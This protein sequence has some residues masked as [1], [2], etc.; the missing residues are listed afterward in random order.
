MIYLDNAATTYPKP[1]NVINSLKRSSLKY[2]ANIGRGGYKMSMDTA[3]MVFKVRKSIADFYDCDPDN[4]VFTLNCTT[5]VN[6]V[7]KGILKSGDHL[8]ISSLE[9]NAV[10]R[11]AQA[12]LKNGVEVSVAEVDL[13]SDERT[14]LNFE[15]LIKPNTKLIFVT[16][17][18]NVFGMRLPINELGE[19]ARNYGIMFGVDGA[20]ESGSGFLSFRNDNMNFLCIAPHKGLYAPL[21]T[22]I[23]ITDKIFDTIIEGGTGTNSLELVQPPFLPERLESGTQ[24]TI[25]ILAIGEGIKFINRTGRDKIYDHEFRLLKR[26]YK[27]LG[28]NP[29]VILYTGEP[30]YNKTAP[31]ISFNVRGFSSEETAAYLSRNNIAVRGGLHCA[32]L[33]HRF[34]KTID[35]GT[36][37]AAFSAFNRDIDCDT[38]TEK[39][40]HMTTRNKYSLQNP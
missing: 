40:R 19:L 36:V 35:T 24:N 18:S 16:A 20:Q 14:V 29:D 10:A 9:H 2:G 12:L 34:M 31:L 3:D 26:T 33:A 4:V 23:L 27:E 30:V 38:L 21:G 15:S 7:L 8:I 17:A 32:P 13:L 5:A 28:K 22:G 6:Y 39:I 25:G 37:R 1:P 11:P